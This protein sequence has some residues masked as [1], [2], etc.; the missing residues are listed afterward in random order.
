VFVALSSMTACASG[1]ADTAAKRAAP[2]S[3]APTTAPVTVP[4]TTQPVVTTSPPT[5]STGSSTVPPATAPA[6]PV[7]RLVGVGSAGQVIAVVAGD[8]GQT[9]ATFT[10]YER[11]GGAWQVAFGPWAARVGTN[12]FAPPGAKREGDERT[13]SGAYGFDFFFGVDPDPGVRFPYRVVTSSAIVWDDDPA[14]AL[15]NEWVD[16]TSQNAGTDPEPMYNTPAYSHG[17][18][19]AYNSARAP[20]LGSAIFLHVSTGGATAGCVSLLASQLLAVLRW[21]DPSQQPR[22]VMGTEAGVTS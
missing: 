15:Y 5:P 18:V 10:A 22:I 16:T 19:I 13:P 6:S 7:D 9:S 14:S 1:D 17:A 21:L 3:V 4:S 8:Y 12:G 11:V 20:G 2:R